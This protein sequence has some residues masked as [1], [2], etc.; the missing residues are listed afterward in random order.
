VTTTINAG[1]PLMNTNDERMRIRAALRHLGSGADLRDFPATA[2]EKI[3]LIKTA[4]Q[5]KL[6]A[7]NRSR[8]CYELTAAGWCELAPSRR[9]GVGSMLVGSAA[10][11]TIGA[12]ALAAFWV[13][14]GPSHQA[15]SRTVAAPPGIS[16]KVASLSAPAVTG[17]TASPA[18]LTGPM[19]VQTASP[20]PA[21][22]VP[23]VE[24]ARE[25]VPA[26]VPAPVAEPTNVAEQP[27]PEQLAEAAAKAKQA[28]AAKKARQ[29]A[30]ARRRREEAARAWAAAEPSRQAEYSGYGGSGGYG[31]QR[32]WFAYR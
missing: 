31:G 21:P 23:A 20:A 29:R 3:A 12:V 32:S 25:T 4:S 13:I 19:P 28:A 6:V 8:G 7:W 14:S 2:S 5:R 22:A 17:A 18:P 15:A 27:S 16:K 30:A 9:F 10:G 24:P 1:H 11:A 26:A